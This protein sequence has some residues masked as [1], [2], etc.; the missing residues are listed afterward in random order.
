MG[1]QWLAGTAPSQTTFTS[2]TTSPATSVGLLGTLPFTSPRSVSTSQLLHMQCY[3]L[4]DLPPTP[5]PSSLPVCLQ[6]PSTLLERGPSGPVGIPADP[7]QL[8]P[9]SCSATLLFVSNVPWHSPAEAVPTFLFLLKLQIPISLLL[10]PPLR[11]R[12]FHQ[13]LSDP[14]VTDQEYL[15]PSSPVLWPPG[16]SPGKA[17]NG[18][19]VSPFREIL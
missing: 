15:F 13:I 17:I 14:P 12:F 2:H 19:S 1:R 10:L 3:C 4:C 6:S 7:F 11:I 16:S 8:G 9:C 18:R 5:P